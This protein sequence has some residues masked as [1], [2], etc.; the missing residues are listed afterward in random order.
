MPNRPRNLNPSELAISDANRFLSPLNT[1]DTN[2]SAATIPVSKQDKLTLQEQLPD[3]VSVTET[4]TATEGYAAH[5]T[6]KNQNQQTERGADFYRYGQARVRTDDGFDDLAAGDINP[7][8]LQPS[9]VGFGLM[10]RRIEEFEDQEASIRI[11]GPKKGSKEEVDL[12]PPYTKFFLQSTQESSQERSQIVETFGD[13]Y[14]F[15]FGKRPEITTFS[16][17]L[18]NAK[19]ASWYNDFKFMYQNFLRGTKCVENNARIVLTFGGTQVEG[20]MLNA[21]KGRNAEIEH[22]VQFSFQL[23]ILDET[24]I[25]FSNDFGLVV[26]DGKIAQS[27]SFLDLLTSSGLAEAEIQPILAHTR[28]ALGKVSNPAKTSKATNNNQPAVEQE[29]GTR[30]VRTLNGGLRLPGGLT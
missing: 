18:L 16:G 26:S 2:N 8:S 9:G 12:I 17:T 6:E 20:L 15:M 19:N 23:L 4:V 1:I 5:P 27:R 10:P 30:L 3:E 7:T 21:S 29:F 24:F 22:G 14:V 25:N 11:V 28:N 13:F